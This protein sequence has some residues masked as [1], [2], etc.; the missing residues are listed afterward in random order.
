[1]EVSRVV[2]F[3]GVDGGE[4][5]FCLS[6]LAKGSATSVYPLLFCCGAGAGIADA[7]RS[8]APKARRV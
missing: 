2:I 1:M 7:G 6:S 8:R 3:D 4:R 5:T